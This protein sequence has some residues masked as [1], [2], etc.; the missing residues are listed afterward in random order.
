MFP[1]DNIVLIISSAQGDVRRKEQEVLLSLIQ[2]GLNHSD[3][4]IIIFFFFGKD[5]LVETKKKREFSSPEMPCRFVSA[6]V[7]LPVIKGREKKRKSTS[8]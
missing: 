8:I 5:F 4:V 7:E 2:T 6:F 1:Q 3:R